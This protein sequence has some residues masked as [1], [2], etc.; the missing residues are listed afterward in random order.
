MQERAERSVNIGDDSLPGP[1]NL[2]SPSAPKPGNPIKPGKLK[3]LAEFW[4]LQ[5]KES[6]GQRDPDPGVE[7]LLGDFGF[8]LYSDVFT[9]VNALNPSHV[10]LL[11]RNTTA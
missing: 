2:V 8:I 1:W 6:F 9:K 3:F 5:S 7:L 10:P 4:H 11:P